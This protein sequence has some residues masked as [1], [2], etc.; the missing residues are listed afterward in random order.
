[1]AASLHPTT[2]SQL[3]AAVAKT[4]MQLKVARLQ[5]QSLERAA[6]WIDRYV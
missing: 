5:R 4:A 1:M 3:K 2:L 6:S